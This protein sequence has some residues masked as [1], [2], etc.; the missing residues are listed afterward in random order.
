MADIDERERLGQVLVILVLYIPY[1]VVEGRFKDTVTIEDMRVRV[2]LL[3]FIGATIATH[4]EDSELSLNFYF[5][6]YVMFLIEIGLELFTLMS[7]L[8][9]ESYFCSL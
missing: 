3:L 2:P 9:F 7:C 1:S 4:I 5:V 8:S 6:Y